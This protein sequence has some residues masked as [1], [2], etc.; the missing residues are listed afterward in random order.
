MRTIT[1]LSILI[2]ILNASLGFCAE[3]VTTVS[4]TKFTNKAA[5]S[6]VDNQNCQSLEVLWT[7]LGDA[8]ADVLIEKLESSPRIEVMEREMLSDIYDQEV[9]LKKFVK[10]TSFF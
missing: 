2:S 6:G 10:T 3:N 5:S 8:F 7:N 9:N 1:Q 4:V